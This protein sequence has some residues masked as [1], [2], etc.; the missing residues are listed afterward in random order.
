[1]GF[2]TSKCSI[3]ED[4]A[5]IRLL[6]KKVMKNFKLSENFKIYNN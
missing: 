5:S 1:M 2:D 3:D 4:D 6:R